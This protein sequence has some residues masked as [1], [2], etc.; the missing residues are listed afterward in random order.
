MI[1]G[2]CVALFMGDLVKQKCTGSIPD[3]IHA[4]V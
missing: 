4:S 1:D 3:R 2:A